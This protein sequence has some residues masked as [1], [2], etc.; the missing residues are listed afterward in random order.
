[1][2]DGEGGD[3]VSIHGFSPLS[4]IT[5]FTAVENIHKG[6]PHRFR[7]RARNAVGWGPFSAEASVLA[8]TKPSAPEAPK[9]SS[10]STTVLTVVVG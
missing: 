9:F 4:M 2:D 10:C 5:H 7:Y 3:F 6:R 1:M 8:A